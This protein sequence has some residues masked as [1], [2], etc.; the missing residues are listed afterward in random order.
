MSS[1]A[2]PVANALASRWD[3]LQ[4]EPPALIDY[5]IMDLTDAL[6]R[7]QRSGEEKQAKCLG[8]V[9]DAFT[10]GV[11]KYE[12]PADSEPT[13]EA[14][15]R[16]V[17]ELRTYYYLKAAEKRRHPSGRERSRTTSGPGR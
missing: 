3:D 12:S 1:S 9:L 2:R 8:E 5:L 7:A 13:E 17:M 14:L 16:S 11:V 6:F 4:A 15:R 10:E